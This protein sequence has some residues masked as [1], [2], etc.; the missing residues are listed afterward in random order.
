MTDKT[1]TTFLLSDSTGLTAE[2]LARG[3]ISQF[4]D[5]ETDIIIKRFITTTDKAQAVV[6]QINAIA[7]KEPLK[8]L[9]FSTIIDTELNAIIAQAEAEIIDFFAPF[10]HRISEHV[11]LQPV[12]KAGQSHSLNDYEAYMNRIE[13]VNFSLMHDDGQTVQHLD[14]AD[15]ILIGISRTGKTPTSIYLS[16][17]YGLRVANFPITEDDLESMRLPQTLQ[18]YRHK[19]FGL[20]TELQALH[21]I[22][23]QRRAGSRYASLRQCDF[24]IRQAEALY[25]RFNV[26]HLNTVTISVEEISAKIIDQ[27]E[28]GHKIQMLRTH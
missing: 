23:E 3:L 20:T 15:I 13:A 28:L 24:E 22:R 6:A 5:L 9:V 25:R 10:L 18:P 14:E 21:E 8:P 1:L 7:A 12:Y 4:T 26:P 16:M 19:L 11:G 2:A 17:H 27:L